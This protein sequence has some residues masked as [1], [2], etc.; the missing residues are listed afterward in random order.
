MEESK[1]FILYDEYGEILS[2]NNGRWP[3]KEVAI[4]PEA[5]GY[6]IL[7]DGLENVDIEHFKKIYLNLETKNFEN[8]TD[9]DLKLPKEIMKGD[10]VEVTVPE[11][12]CLIING[13]KHTSGTIELDTSDP[14]KGI[15]IDS[16]GKH[17]A[18]ANQR[19]LTYKYQR[20]MEYPSIEK[21]LDE[22]YHNG[23]DAWKAKIKA[24]KDKYPKS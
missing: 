17:Y 13:S 20:G 23:I 8:K 1:K 16:K 7:S 12:G 5:K 2:L 22:I 11:N 18:V 10:K 9:Y 21:Q 4:H 3:D 24:V 14:E 15:V 19:V 6:I